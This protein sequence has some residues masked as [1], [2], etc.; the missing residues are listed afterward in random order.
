MGFFSK[1]F[2]KSEAPQATTTLPPHIAEAL[3]SPPRLINE[4]PEFPTGAIVLA[5]TVTPAQIDEAIARAGFTDVT[6]R[7][8]NGVTLLDASLEAKRVLLAVLPWTNPR[9][10]YETM[11]SPS[12]P[13][14]ELRHAL[15]A[16]RHYKCVG[17]VPMEMRR[18][19][20]PEIQEIVRLIDRD[21]MADAAR[22]QRA[23]KKG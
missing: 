20:D 11:P 13:L 7:T 2:G 9:D 14:P 18:H 10:I 16:L 12:A 19:A 8:E 15:C 23:R 6:H 1:L 5:P 22:A 3:K 17:G 21:Q 4:G